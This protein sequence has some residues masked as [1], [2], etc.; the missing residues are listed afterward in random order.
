MRISLKWKFAWF[1]AVLLLFTIAI[2]S[3]SI[4]NGVADYQREQMESALNQQVQTAQTQITQQYV[5]GTR[6]SPRSFMHVEGQKLAVHAGATSGMRVLMYDA[7]GALVGDSL[8]MADRA[9]VQDA[10]QAALQNKIAYLIEG[11]TLQY[12]APIHCPDGQLGVIH[13]QSSLAAQHAFFQELL[14]LF[15]YVGLF[16]LVTSFLFGLFYMNRQASAITRLKTETDQIRTG[17]YREAPVLHRQ[18]ELGDL[19]HGIFE[20]SQAIESSIRSQK[21]FINN[22]S[23]EFKTPLTSIMA[24]ADLLLMYGD[25]PAMIRESGDAIQK[26]SSRLYE[27]V[28]KALQ[29]AALE[30][31]EFEHQPEKVEVHTLLEDLCSR[32]NGK[33]N[34]LGITILAQL[35]PASIWADRTS[36]VHI[37]LNLLDNAIKYNQEQGTVTVS[38]RHIGNQVE[39]IIQDT[40]IGIPDEAK[41]RIFEPFYT[42]TTDRARKSGGTGLGLALVHQLVEKQNGQIR[43]ENG[44]DGQGTSFILLFAAYIS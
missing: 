7:D 27:L 12:L 29:L 1:L 5:T 18:D 43:V 34:Q 26:E 4:L 19:S 13:F 11:D 33:A 15:L 8:P 21:Q 16:V 9:E 41:K 44:K 38:S 42:V 28:E 2:L 17:H 35:E 37:L 32:L 31:Y 14:N 10:L 36:M 20:M 22:I 24:N 6:V 25:D 3:S 30:K 23:H 39:I 40:G